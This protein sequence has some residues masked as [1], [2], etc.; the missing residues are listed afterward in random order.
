MSDPL[1]ALAPRLP[2]PLQ[3]AHDERFARHGVRLL[4]KRDDLIHP[5]LPEYKTAGEKRAAAR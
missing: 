4:L 2:S 5:A 3:E 1:A